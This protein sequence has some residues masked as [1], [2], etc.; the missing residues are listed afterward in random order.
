MGKSEVLRVRVR[1]M[2]LDV[3]DRCRTGSSVFLCRLNKIKLAFF[4]EYSPR[5]RCWPGRFCLGMEST[6]R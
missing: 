2:E 6:G 4:C 1:E 3:S 5:F